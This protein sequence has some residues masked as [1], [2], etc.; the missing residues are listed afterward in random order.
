ML[1]SL[2]APHPLTGVACDA[3]AYVA[4]VGRLVRSNRHRILQR[5][6]LTGADVSQLQNGIL[7][8][9]ELEADLIALRPMAQ[10]DIIDTGDKQTPA[11]H[12]TT[13][14]DVYRQVGLLQLY[15]CFPDVLMKRL[16]MDMADP[17]THDAET[18]G[19]STADANEWMTSFAL[20]ILD[21]IRTIP[22]ESGTKDFQ[23]FLL[24]ATCSELRISP[25]DDAL[26]SSLLSTPTTTCPQVS[27]HAARIHQA[28]G[29]LITRL[30][31]F[32]HSLPRLP[33]QRCVKIVEATWKEMDSSKG[34]TK[35]STTYWMD[36]M[37][38]N[39]W[40]TFMA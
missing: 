8:A 2:R 30:H 14:R 16:S 26:Y 18:T 33:M 13:L 5:D 34:C 37:I 4:R 38:K 7:R 11:W 27:L 32:Q 9:F 12:L 24:V 29:F 3:H 6:F 17:I 40:E 20:R 39:G 22:A 28:R 23:P 21:A 31:T 25:L 10:A 15:R 1:P 35:P 36:V 19:S